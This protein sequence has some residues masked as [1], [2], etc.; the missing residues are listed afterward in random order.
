MHSL[1]STNHC[2]KSVRIRSYSGPH[3]P[4]F[5]LR[6]SVSLHIQSE[7]GKMR[8]RITPNTDTFYAENTKKNENDNLVAHKIKFFNKVRF[9][10]SSL[11]NLAGNL[12]QELRK[13]KCENCKS[14]LD[15]TAFKD[16]TR[17]LKCLECN[18]NY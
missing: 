16:H 12:G 17:T 11:S 13:G 1:L 3:S 4:A 15:Y 9:M 18:K 7:C 8:T 5:G 14:G 6:Y 10:V 2:V